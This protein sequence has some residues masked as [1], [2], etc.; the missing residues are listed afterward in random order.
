LDTE[1]KIPTAT[2]KNRPREDESDD[3]SMVALDAL[4]KKIIK[5]PKSELDKRIA[6]EKQGHH[7][8]GTM[9]PVS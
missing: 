9:P 1:K 3:P 6:I 2:Q 5:V 7:S 4:V 8:R